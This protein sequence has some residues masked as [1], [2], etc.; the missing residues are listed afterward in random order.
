MKQLWD[1]MTENMIRFNDLLS[2]MAEYATEPRMKKAAK[3]M[4]DAW[5]QIIN[6]RNELDRFIEPIQPD[7]IQL[8][9][10][11]QEFSNIWK[12]YREYLVEE[13]QTHIG[14]RR[15][16]MILKKIKSMSNGNERMAIDMIEFFIYNGYKSIFKPSEKQLSGSEPV[17]TEQVFE[18]QQTKKKV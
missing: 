1:N 17:Q 13:H 15:E 6:Q 4:I 5:N 9:F 3:K 14:S 10:E 16:N 2:Q 12:T 7:S 8:P 18:Y 11:S